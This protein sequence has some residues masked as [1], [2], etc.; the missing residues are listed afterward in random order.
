MKS[1]SNRVVIQFGSYFGDRIIILFHSNRFLK[2]FSDGKWKQ[3][4]RF[5]RSINVELA[6]IDFFIFFFQRSF[7]DNALGNYLHSRFYVCGC[8][9]FSSFPPIQVRGEK[10]YFLKGKKFICFSYFSIVMP[11]ICL[12]G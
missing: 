3:Q 6:T 9:V 11:P 8:V 12:V 1:K 4:A 7:T 10:K 2:I 5:S